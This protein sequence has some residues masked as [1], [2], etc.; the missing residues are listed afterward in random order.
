MPYVLAV[1][2]NQRVI[3]TVD[4]TVDRAPRRRPGGTTARAG[5]EEDLRRRRR[6]GTTALPLGPDSD[7]AAGR[8]PQL[9][10]AGPPQ[11]DRSA[12]TWPTTCATA[13]NAPRCASWSASPEPAGRSRRPSRPP[14][15]KSASTST[16]SAATTAG[17]DTSPWP[18]SPTPSSPSPPPRPVEKGGPTA[19]RG[20]DP[21]HRPRGPTPARPTDLAP[22]TRRPCR[23]EL[24]PL[25]TP[26]PSPR[27]TMP[28]HQPRRL[29]ISAAV[30]L[31]GWIDQPTTTE[32][33]TN[34]TMT[35]IAK[36]TGI[37]PEPVI[38]SRTRSCWPLLRRPKCSRTRADRDSRS[39]TSLSRCSTLIARPSSGVLGQRGQDPDQLPV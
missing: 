32:R 1:P 37:A 28:L 11:P 24:V 20:T 16:R 27:P 7:P 12:P 3:A 9:L 6:Q 31:V 36:V 39:C 8:H 5:V 10:A 34:P 26:T 13:P 33:T 25:A 29:A 14:R 15:A 23:P 19:G 38:H 35:K 30:V 18:C 17:T 22:T 2:V 21:A 4:G